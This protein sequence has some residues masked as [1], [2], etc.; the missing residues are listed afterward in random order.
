MQQQINAYKANQEQFK[1]EEDAFNSE[2]AYIQENTNVL[3]VALEKL[4]EGASD[5]EK[6]QI[7]DELFDVEKAAFEVET[8]QNALNKTQESLNAQEAVLKEKENQ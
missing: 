4:A 8:A 2:I 5:E 1:A 7:V 6:N 3:Q